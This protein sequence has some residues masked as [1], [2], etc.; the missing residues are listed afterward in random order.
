MERLCDS[1]S[2]AVKSLRVGPAEKRISALLIG[3][4][5][6]G[7]GTTHC[8]SYRVSNFEFGTE[9]L[10]MP[11]DKFEICRLTIPG[12]AV[13]DVGSSY[14]TQSE[15]DKIFD[16]LGNPS[17]PPEETVKCAVEVVR[18]VADR[19]TKQVIGRRCSSVVILYSGVLGGTPVDERVDKIHFV[20]TVCAVYGNK[21]A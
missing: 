5:L 16:L 12:A 6:D 19:D 20:T 13:C 17:V 18:S 21:G 9:P 8:E 2:E 3:Y 14:P 10:A 15:K 1:L 4:R 11:R 7:D